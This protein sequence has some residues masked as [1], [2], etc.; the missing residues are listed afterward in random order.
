MK[1]LIFLVL[2]MLWLA[3]RAAA[4]S[5]GGA[6]RKGNEYY[7]V[8]QY[9]LA[10]AQY[11][12]ALDKN[13]QN[14][15]ARFNLANAIYQQKR[16]TEAHGLLKKLAEGTDDAAL[17]AAVYYNDGVVYTKEQNLD[18]SIEAYKRAL[19]L[20]PADKQAR[21]NL[22]K[23]LAERKR[24]EQQRKDQQKKQQQSS[25]MSQK[26]AEQKLQLLQQKEKR[27]QERLQQGGQ[28]GNS[29]PQDW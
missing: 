26:E 4:Q 14:A 27:L 15:T 25:K 22:Q 18:A 5:P 1:K 2:L 12:T 28:K 9:A 6:V 19:R 7:R 29:Q 23:A 8:Q 21:E 20:Q 24:Q 11:K 16:Y 10:E 3:A 17:K 13:P